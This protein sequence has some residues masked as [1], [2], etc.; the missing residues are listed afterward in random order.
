MVF[1]RT[2][3]MVRT[4]ELQANQLRSLPERVLFGES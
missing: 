4:I 1:D 2:I 3:A